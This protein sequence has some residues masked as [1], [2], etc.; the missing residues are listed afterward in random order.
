MPKCSEAFQPILKR[1]MKNIAIKRS[2]LPSILR[3]PF[4][5]APHFR[6]PLLGLL[7]F[8]KR[9]KNVVLVNSRSKTKS[10]F[11]ILLAINS[12]IIN[13][14]N[15]QSGFDFSPLARSAYDK[16]LALKFDEANALIVELR[17]KEPNNAVA[18][19]IENYEDCLKVFISE[20]QNVFDALAPK[21][22]KRLAVLKGSDASSPYYLYAQA[23]SRLL[24]AMNRAKFGEYLTAFNETSTAFGLLETNQKKFPTF[25][26]NKMS[27]GILH[28]IIGTIPDS[29]KWGVKLLGGMNGTTAQGQAEIEQVIHYAKSNDFVFEQEALVMY[30][31]LTLHLNNQSDNA[32]QL[33][34]S[35]KLKPKENLLAA[36][37]LSN[38][39]MRTGRNDKAIEIL[40]NRPTNAAYFPF[41]FL[42][43][44]LGLAK[45]FR[46]DS[47]ADISIKKYVNT[48]HGRNY[49]K[50]AYQR[51]AWF[52]LLKGNW[53]GYKSYIEN[54]KTAGKSDIGG[55]KNALKEAK[56][57]IVPNGDLLRTRLLFDGGYFQKAYNYLSQKNENA[58]GQQAEKLEFSYRMGRILQ[59]LKKPNEAIAYFDK[60]IQS[61][62]ST[63][64]Y[65]ACNA[66][67]QMGTIY[68][69]YGNTAKSREYYNFCLDLNPD[70]YADGLHSKAKAGLGRL[71]NKK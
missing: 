44:Q 55:D 58:F 69:D 36:F 29:Y 48:F 23:Q 16:M 18:Y 46:G 26:P 66:A 54:C 25:M 43:Y 45:M 35:P 71:K 28:A 47:D 42:D 5:Y 27:L 51:L 19:Y 21:A 39:A 1:K 53:N 8:T 13:V 20:D 3:G 34:N 40:Q 32:W 50:E 62:K 9:L 68:E 37:A 60:T 12:L 64:Y 11:A 63:R 59:M 6:K 70:D 61:G 65:Y 4:F 10:L 33:I 67:L 49:L 52:E 24:W 41:P 22:A 7:R 56:T 2:K 15:A 38:V 30:A 31:F 17:R 14:L 57:G